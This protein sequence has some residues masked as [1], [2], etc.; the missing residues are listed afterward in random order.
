MSC[1]SPY[2]Q[3]LQLPEGRCMCTTT[4][5][6]SYDFSSGSQS[7]TIPGWKYRNDC[8]TSKLTDT[9]TVIPKYKSLNWPYKSSID[10]L[11]C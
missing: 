3:T 5:S 8:Y 2:K 11:C 6:V 9:T 1:L 7:I 4:R 10:L